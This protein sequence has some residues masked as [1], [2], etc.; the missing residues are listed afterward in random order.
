MKRRGNEMNKSGTI[1]K[2]VLLAG[3]SML[4]LASAGA[5]FAQTATTEPVETVTVTGSRVVTDALQAPTPLTV[6]SSAQLEA[7]TP[8]NIPDGLNKLPV[9]QGSQTIGQPGGGGTNSASNVLSL[10]SFGSNRTLVMMDGH[11]IT[12]SNAD[13]TVDIDSLPQML[14]SRVDIVTGGA[15]AV[16]GSDAVTGVVNFILDKKFDGVKFDVNGGI[17]SYGDAATYKTAVAAGTDLFHG[18]GHIEGSIEYRNSDPLNVFARPYGPLTTLQSGSGTAASPFVTVLN[19]RR[20]NSTAGGLV[21]SCVPACTTGAAGVVGVGANGLN[22]IANGILGPFN[23]GTTT[24]TANQNSGGD[25]AYTPYATALAASRQS[26]VFGR[27]SYDIDN[28]TTFYLQA[29][30]AEAYDNGWHFPQKLTPGTGLAQADVFYKNNPFLTAA[31]M[32]QLGNNGT[33]P[34]YVPNGT[35]APAQPQNTFQVGEFL[36]SQGQSSLNG[37]LGVNRN[38]SVQAG[39]DGS[40]MGGRFSWN[41]YYT[42]GE[43]RL[44]E[45]LANN[46]NYQKLFA[47]EDAVLNSNGTIQCYASTQAATAAAYADCVP[48]NPFGPTAVTASAFNYTKQTTWFHQTNILDDLGAGI[49]GKVV[50]GWAGPINASLSAEMRFNDYAVTTNV[51]IA[52]VDCTG[53]RLC[54]PNLPLYAQPVLAPV[55]ANSNVWEIAGEVE[56]PLLKDMPLVRSLDA[57]IAGR[58]TDYSISGAVQTW[59]LGLVYEVNDE[60]RFRGTTS[61][62][63][64]A[65]T[66][67][68]LY[69]PATI[70]VSGYTD[71]HTNFSST[72]FISTQGNVNLVPEVARTYTVGFVW[73]PEFISN[74]SMSLDYFRIRMHNSIGS[75]SASSTTIQTLCN[76]SGGTSIYCA[77]YQRP[78]AFSDTTPANYP[79]RIFNQSLNTAL[80]QTEGF[81]F[82]T[83]YNFEMSDVVADW[84]GSW[85]ARLLGSYQPVLETITFPGSPES[86]TTSPKTRVTTFLN[87]TLRDW[88]IGV[89]DRWLGG[90]SQVSTAG[91]VYATPY[92]HSFNELDATVQRKFEIDRS[93]VTGYLTVQNI[94]NAQP[95]LL[96]S[97]TI[98]EFYPT[99]AGQDIRGR[100]FT[101]GVRADL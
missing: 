45:D 37:G 49:S 89:Q 32:G 21:Q 76:N 85:S 83:N 52:N 54:N 19:G 88:M 5:A 24:A 96:G 27:F 98:G 58:Y 51:P 68:D 6:I 30:G 41:A 7:T 14:V 42:H 64:R 12:P 66:L 28:T 92:V 46:Q 74:L 35:G 34:V 13:G 8:T 57:N 15:S 17:S 56:V 63:I 79:T 99:P 18:R 67:S 44:A 59:K 31:V 4:V 82:E 29:Q 40:L 60:F 62:D 90:Y 38:L 78:N 50:D 101:I 61:I 2:Q 71:L 53:L 25:G 39:L 94:L 47:A 93:E 65:P 1:N 11:R 86:R 84:S 36:Q 72:T 77:L 9:F 3:A 26:S 100:Y 10:R 70:A 16:Y 48:I 22:F 69:Q 97:S 87:Y 95:A 55:T 91:Q 75:I 73:T 81:D 33:N 20:P 23:P 80:Q 43:N